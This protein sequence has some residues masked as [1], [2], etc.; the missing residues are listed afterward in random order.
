MKSMRGLVL[1]ALACAACAITTE[2]PVEV[3]VVGA[4]DLNMD[5][6]AQV[7][8][9]V[10]AG[11]PTDG[12]E[13]VIEGDA[14]LRVTDYAPKVLPATTPLAGHQVFVDLVPKSRGDWALTV[15]LTFHLAGKRPTRTLTLP[16]TVSSPI[17]VLPLPEA[18]TR[19]VSGG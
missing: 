5:W 3:K 13:I 10:R 16:L 7:L 17:T 6:P 12:I 15:K 4:P 11:I 1:A 18:V 9:D 19:G 2:V 14:G 8:L